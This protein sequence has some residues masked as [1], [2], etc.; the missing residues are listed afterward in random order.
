MD[1]D[2]AEGIVMDSYPGPLGQ[3]AINLINNAYL[4]AF[5]GRTD[6]TVRIAGQVLQGWV[7]VQVSDDGAGMNQDLLAQLF[8]PFF[9]TKIGRGGTGLG[10]TIV[11]NLVQK[12]LG[13]TLEVK[14]SPGQGS[15]FTLRIPLQV[16]L[17]ENYMFDAVI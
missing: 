13:G 12:T 5:E 2:I 9:S 10:M 8:Q 17:V 6:G 1:C 16:A 14:S 7:H 4:H 15:S 3:V 11:E